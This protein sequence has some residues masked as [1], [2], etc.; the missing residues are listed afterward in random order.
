MTTSPT[1]TAAKP[2]HTIG[3][4]PSAARE[5]VAV[6]TQH[7]APKSLTWKEFQQRYRNREDRNKY[8]WVNGRVEKTPRSMDQKQL[9]V[10]RNL[11]Q[12][13][14]L[15]QNSDP[16][17]GE[18][19]VETDTFLSETIHRKPDIAYFSVAQILAAANGDYQI[20]GFVIEVISPSD[21]AN[22]IHRKVREYFD[23]GVQVLWQIFPELEE[24]HIHTNA[25]S[26][27]IARGPAPCSAE[28]VIPGFVLS[29]EAVFAR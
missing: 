26:N 5:S 17:I 18:L 1:S 11:N 8:E 23:A 21:T 16:T 28:A 19:T 3:A 12:F 13:L 22:R 4:A 7:K 15:L 20:P 2:A 29:A 9:F 27:F 25:T 24:V 6:H 10:L 14:R